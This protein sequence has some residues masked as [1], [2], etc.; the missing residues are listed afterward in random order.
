MNMQL[1]H[2]SKKMAT[3]LMVATIVTLLLVYHLITRVQP[4]TASLMSLL[5]TAAKGI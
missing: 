2:T 3:H 5:H 1:Q 4:F